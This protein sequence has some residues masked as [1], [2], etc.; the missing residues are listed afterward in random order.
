[1]GVQYLEILK[2][3][4]IPTPVIK[5]NDGYFTNDLFKQF[6]VFL[7]ISDETIRA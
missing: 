7:N 6:I 3:T 5:P 2:N 4:E 1:M